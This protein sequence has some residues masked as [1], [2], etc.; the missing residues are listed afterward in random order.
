[1]HNNL[2]TI[3]SRNEDVIVGILLKVPSSQREQSIDL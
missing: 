1:M 3:I 2:F